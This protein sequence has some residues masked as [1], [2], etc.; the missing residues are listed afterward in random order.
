[1][2]EKPTL[3]ESK[4]FYTLLWGIAIAFGLQVILDGLLFRFG[5]QV[6]LEL[7][8]VIYLVLMIGLG[9]YQRE[10]RKARKLKK[11]NRIESV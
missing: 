10:I 11:F 4:E 9:V 1:M 2:G 5:Q 8:A 3:K 6:G 7:S